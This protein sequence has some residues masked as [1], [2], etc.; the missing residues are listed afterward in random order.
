VG[1]AKGQAAGKVVLYARVSIEE[2]QGVATHS[3]N[4]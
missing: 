1:D 3:H 4:N 2:Q